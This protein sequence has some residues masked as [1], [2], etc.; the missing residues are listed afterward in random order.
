MKKQAEDKGRWTQRRRPTRPRFLPPARKLA[1]VVWGL[2]VVELLLTPLLGCDPFNTKFDDDAVPAEYRAQKLH[3]PEL[4]GEELLVM[5]YNV[6][7]AGGRVDFFFDCHGDRALMDEDEV[8]DHLEGLAAKIRQ[9]DPDIILLQ[10]VDVASKRS[11]YVDMMQWLLDNTDLNYGVYAS[12]W[13]ADYIPSDG[14]GPMDSGNAILSRWPLSDAAR[15]PLDLVEEQDGLTQYFWLRRNVLRTRVEVPR[16]EPVWVLNVHAEA[17]SRDG[18]KKKH[19]DAF[20]AELDVLADQGQF[21]IGGGD[22]NA[23]PPGSDKL[24]GFE[25]SICEGEFEADDYSGETDW[26]DPLYTDYAEVIPTEV[27]VADQARYATHTTDKDGFWNRRLDYL[28][29]NGT[30]RDGLVHQSIE[31]GG[32]E[33]M[34]LSDHAPVTGKVKP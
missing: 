14:L 17:Y 12:H 32:M 3:E 1:R 4:P 33:T 23:L 10:E 13:K 20:K 6:K 29:T 27:Y 34:P 7:F 16:Y 8:L 26:L 2:A 25:D 28:F 24:D 15:I 22:L 11:A 18:T 5:T 21:V 30:W 19:I 9:V 31:L